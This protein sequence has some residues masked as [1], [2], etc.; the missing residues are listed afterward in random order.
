MARFAACDLTLDVLLLQRGDFFWSV[1]NVAEA[2]YET[3]PGVRMPGRENLLGVRV[4][5][6]E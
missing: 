2:R 3:S 4:R 6:L 1:R 5:L